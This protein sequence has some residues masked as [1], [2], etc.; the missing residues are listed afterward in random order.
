MKKV[1]KKI[2]ISFQKYGGMFENN[3]FQNLRLE[4]KAMEW[5]L[6]EP[7]NLVGRRLL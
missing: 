5:L 3:I 6:R 1:N 4:K 7:V 2:K